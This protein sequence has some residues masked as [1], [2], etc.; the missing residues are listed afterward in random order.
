MPRKKKPLTLANVGK[1]V[2]FK[3]RKE[4]ESQLVG[5]LNLRSVYQVVTVKADYGRNVRIAD[6]AGLTAEGTSRTYRP[7]LIPTAQA[8]RIQVYPLPFL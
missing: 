3:I 1:G 5:G 4:S 7:L 8:K 2:V 6:M